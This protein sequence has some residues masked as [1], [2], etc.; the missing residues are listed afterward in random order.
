MVRGNARF[1]VS[2]RSA[3]AIRKWIIRSNPDLLVNADK[4]MLLRHGHGLTPAQI[5]E[6]SWEVPC[7]DC[8]AI[9]EGLR[10]GVI[11]FCCPK[12]Q[13]LNR[14]SSARIVSIT[15][16][17]FE[18]A[19]SFAGGRFASGASDVTAVPRASLQDVIQAALEKHGPEYPQTQGLP[20]RP[21]INI[22]MRVKRYQALLYAGWTPK[23]Y[24]DH[25]EFCLIRFI[26]AFE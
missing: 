17:L 25:I 15:P 20:S 4:W 1:G 21:Q 8:G 12:Q 7:S 14:A 9:P 11:E 5:V 13:C 22:P 26:Q 19:K 3:E 10:H 23:E 24:S 18:K 2:V 6:L 16:E